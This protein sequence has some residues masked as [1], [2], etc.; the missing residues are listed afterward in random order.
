MSFLKHLGTTASKFEFHFWIDH[1]VG[2][3]PSDYST[4]KHS[5]E[6]IYCI[7]KRKSKSYRT[8]IALPENGGYVHLNDCIKFTSTLYQK[9]KRHQDLSAMLPKP[10]I[11][12]VCDAKLA[13]I[14]WET[15]LDLSDYAT[16]FGVDAQE[17]FTL[18]FSVESL[19]RSLHS[20][21]L[22]FIAPFIFSKRLY[23]NL[24]QKSKLF[25]S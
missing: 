5:T 19:Y 23:L 11:L 25:K 2:V 6:G 4:F 13:T 20:L 16:V 9:K 22:I 21:T 17:S 8:K 14:R 1:V 7:L 18:Q 3:Y 10:F 15:T 12:R 24:I